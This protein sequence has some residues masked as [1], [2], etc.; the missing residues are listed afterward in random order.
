LNLKEYLYV[1]QKE[2]KGKLIR[3]KFKS[4]FDSRENHKEPEK[5]NLCSDYY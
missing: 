1:S 4:L 5:L 3:E 2:K